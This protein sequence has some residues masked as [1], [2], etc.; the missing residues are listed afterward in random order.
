MRS[1]SLQA[2][3]SLITLSGKI[4]KT[5]QAG[6]LGANSV[7]ETARG[8]RILDN[9]HAVISQRGRDGTANFHLTNAGFTFY[10]VLLVELLTEECVLFTELLYSP[11]FA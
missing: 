6:F 5:A 9:G 10:Q 11:S 3:L 8:L 1:H 2:Q 4:D 7:T